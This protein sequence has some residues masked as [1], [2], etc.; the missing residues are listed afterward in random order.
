MKIAA[1]IIRTLIGLLLLVVSIG[2]FLKLMPKPVTNGDFKAFKIGF[3][4]SEY[5]MPIV[6]FVTFLCGLAF[7]FDRY[8]TI[9]SLLILPFTIN[10]LFLTIT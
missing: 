10:I 4:S 3:V 8:I 7:I 2:Y 9:A 5:L 6:K 1:I